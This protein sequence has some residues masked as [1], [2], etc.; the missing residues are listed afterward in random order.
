MPPD[1]VEELDFRG[2]YDL[3]KEDDEE[4]FFREREEEKEDREFGTRYHAKSGSVLNQ[5][6]AQ[7]KSLAE[8]RA[9]VQRQNQGGNPAA[10]IGGQGP[11]L[12]SGTRVRHAQFGD[13][14]ILRREKVGNDIKLTIT[15]SRA[16]KKTLIERYAKLQAI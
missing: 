16:G 4:G 11:I 10:S 13:G 1:L 2:T 12:K 6:S 8:L 5:P 9:Y 7:P 14:I 3:V 15:F